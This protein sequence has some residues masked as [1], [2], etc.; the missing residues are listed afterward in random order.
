MLN[1]RRI[2]TAR[3]WME[4]QMM[5]INKTWIAAGAGLAVV[6][7]GVV[8][9]VAVAGDWGSSSAS[10]TYSRSDRAAG[11]SARSARS[12]SRGTRG[13]AMMSLMQFDANKDGRVTR[14]EVEA[15]IAAQFHSIDTNGDGRLDASEYQRF[16]DA[17]RAERKARIAAWRASGQDGSPPDIALTN[18]DT[19]KR[20]DWNLDGYIT[21][22]E[23]GGRF[24]ALA[25]R[26]DRD[27]DGTILA[28]ELKQG[29]RGRGGRQDAAQTTPTATTAPAV[30]GQ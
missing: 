21:P 20:L 11:Q 27:G 24:R 28:D 19:M 1:P 8:G 18:Y 12:S 10:P 22:D 25:M 16:T 15:G 7:V 5:T 14:A 23:F 30:G 29:T 2:A 17:R 3:A 13:S 9:V 26:A 4:V 6:V